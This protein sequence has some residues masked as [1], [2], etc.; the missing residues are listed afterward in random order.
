MRRIVTQIIFPVL[1]AL[2]WGTAFVAQSSSADLIDAMTFNTARS[3]VAFVVL[4]LL[5]QIFRR[6][7][8]KDDAVSLTP[9]EK[10]NQFKGLIWGGFCCGTAL[11]L[12]CNL[13]QMGIVAGT[14]AGKTSFITTMY[15]V[16]VPICG[17]FLK[18]RVPFSVWISVMLA[19]AGL[20]CLCIKEDFS[21]VFSDFLVLLCAFAYTLQILVVDYFA[22]KYNG[23]ELSCVQ[24]FFTSIWSAIGMFIFE[25]PDWGNIMACMG[26]ILYVGVFSSG[27][28]YTLQIL[29]QKDSDNPTVVTLLLSLESVFGVLAGAVFL[30][31]TM[32]GKEY[33]GCA[34]MLVA[35]VLAQ[36]P[37]PT[38]KKTARSAEQ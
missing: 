38:R 37:M 7:E 22:P 34:L 12:A 16:L 24:F 11:A 18:K 15:V 33:L 19:V 31:E 14:S 26:D 10:K 20:Y 8:K 30:H 21:I 9:E 13:Q 1:T 36:I 2:I 17:L 3:A 6:F 29:A 4:L 25:S 28:A 23:I 32:T 35:V 27:V 5:V